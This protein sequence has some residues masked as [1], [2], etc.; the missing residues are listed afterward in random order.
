LQPD[1]SNG[2]RRLDIPAIEELIGRGARYGSPSGEAA[3]Y[4]GRRVASSVEP[5]R[6]DRRHF[7]SPT[8]PPK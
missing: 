1:A 7:T 2:Y 6:L 5:T 3:S 4:E 8:T